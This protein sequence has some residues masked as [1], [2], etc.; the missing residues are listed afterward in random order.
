MAVAGGRHSCDELVGCVMVACFV[1]GLVLACLL[2]RSSVEGSVLQAL[3]NYLIFLYVHGS[4]DDGALR[5]ARGLDGTGMEYVCI[6]TYRSY[7]RVHSSSSCTP[8][9]PLPQ[10]AVNLLA[11]PSFSAVIP[12]DIQ[13]HLRNDDTVSGLQAFSWGDAAIVEC[14]IS[15]SSDASR[16]GLGM[17]SFHAFRRDHGAVPFSTVHSSFSWWLLTRHA[18]MLDYMSKSAARIMPGRPKVTGRVLSLPRPDFH[19]PAKPSVA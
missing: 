4:C 17:G 14:M 12:C 11:P 3:T 6:H 1:A 18:P 19:A 8:P 5:T 13:R 9:F 2:L 10:H 15:I 16:D 7:I